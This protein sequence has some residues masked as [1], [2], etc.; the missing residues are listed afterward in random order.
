MRRGRRPRKGLR[1]RLGGHASRSRCWED[2]RISARARY[3][4]LIEALRFVARQ[5]VI[6]GL[7]VHVG[8]DDPDKAIHVANGMRVHVPILLAL[9]ANSP[10]WRAR[11]RPGSP[12]PGCRSSAPSRASGIPP[13][14]EDWDDYAKRIEFMVEASVIEDYTY[15][16]YDVRPH[17]NFG[18]V[19]I[20]AM[21]AQTRVEHTLGLAALIQAMVKELAEHYEAGKQARAL[22]VRDARR[23]QVARRAPRARR[24]ARRPARAP[25][26][27][28]PRSSPGALYDRLREHAQ[29]LG[30]ADEL[31]GVLDLLEH[32]N[33]AAPPAR[34]LRGE[35]RSRRGHARDRGEDRRSDRSRAEGRESVP[36]PPR[37]SYPRDG[38]RTSSRSSRTTWPPGEPVR[39]GEP[40][41]RAAS[42]QLGAE[43]Q[44][45]LPTVEARVPDLFVVCKNCGSEVSP[46]ITECPYCGTRLRKRAPKLE[47]GG[48]P[49]RPGGAQRPSLQ[50]P[51]A[52]RDPG[53]PG[54]RAGPTRRS[55]SS[56]RRS[57]GRRSAARAR[58]TSRRP[59]ARAPAST[60]SYWRSVTTLFVYGRP[61]YE[62]V[63]LAAVFLF[64]WLLE[65][66]HGAWAP[67]LVFLVG[68]RGRHR[69]SR[70]RPATPIA[71][72]RQRRRARPARRVGDARL[73][74]RR[75]GDEDDA[76]LL[77]VLAIAAC[78]CCCPLVAAEAERRSPASPAASIGA[79]PRAW[80]SPRL[81]ER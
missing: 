53:H 60:T 28:R 49:K 42:A 70:S 20:R 3:R 69:W 30:S 39:D 7:H 27:C 66:R 18:T 15:L 58:S 68:G 37:R 44:R 50:P 72:R 65:R 29:D 33:G 52:G 1:D 24:R 36:P 11:R 31:E 5:E 81:R 51:A 22:P 17:P 71:L 47:R 6:F 4:E 2:Q 79:D 78:S 57:S 76:D 40:V 75:R 25:S 19:E 41:L 62:V 8:I 21:D 38:E 61:R 77:G 63:A 45:E 54:R 9:S 59:R 13:Y 64:G 74:G 48:T 12:R 55:C 80:R 16:W 10:F 67:L 26:A 73:L 46:Y 43:D 32:G 35:P 14:Y 23:E 56:S 34:R